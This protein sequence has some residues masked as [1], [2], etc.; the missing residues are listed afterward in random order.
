MYRYYYIYHTC[1]DTCIDTIHMYNYIYILFHREPYTCADSLN[2]V[3][4]SCC[5]KGITMWGSA[6]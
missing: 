6:K 1:M 3:Q 2:H 5:E 4:I